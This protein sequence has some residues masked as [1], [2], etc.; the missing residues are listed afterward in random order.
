[1]NDVFYEFMR[2]TDGIA[3]SDVLG[4]IFAA[5]GGMVVYK[6][7]DHIQTS[8]ERH[9]MLKDIENTFSAIYN[10]V[11]AKSGNDKC[12]ENLQKVMVRSVLH[13]DGDWLVQM[14][15]LPDG[16]ERL[17]ND[18]KIVDSQLFVQIRDGVGKLPE[19][20][21]HNEWISTQ[22]LHE[23]MLHCRRIE[24]MFKDGIIKRIDLSDMFREIV[25]LGMS[26]RMQFFYAYY[27]KYDADCVGYLVLQTIVSCERYQNKDIIASFAEYY[28]LHPEIHQFF[29]NSNRIRP[30]IDRRAVAKFEKICNSYATEE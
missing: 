30:V 4:W 18:R 1:M 2:I 24:K 8:M 19:E 23:I 11:I 27:S 17:C 7:I 21:Y 28:N 26:G 29:V 5:F 9:G 20:V 15:K 13:D 3:M 10:S 16:T 6:A 14:K 12:E 22:A 25:P